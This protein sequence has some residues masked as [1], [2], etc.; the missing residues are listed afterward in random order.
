MIQKS[1]PIAENLILNALQL[2]EQLH[3]L[4]IEEADTLQKP[5]QA[6]LIDSIATDKKKLV[7]QLEEF[8][9]QCGQVLATEELPNNQEGIGAYF[10]RATSAGLSAIETTQHWVAIQSLCVK[11]KAL[12]EQNGASV[13]LLSFHTQRSLHILKGDAQRSNTYGANGARKN[14][15]YTHTL[16]SV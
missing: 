5:L 2:T 11:C 1:W 13:E 3:Q 4:L 6:D 12:N 10:Q 16:I 8:N 15:P 7:S 9:L 14:D